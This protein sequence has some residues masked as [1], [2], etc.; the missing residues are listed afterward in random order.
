MIDNNIIQSLG[1]GSGIDTSNLTKQLTNIERT[2]PQN[3]IDTKRENTEN[4]ISDFGLISSA[5]ATLQDAAEV[6]SNPEG[7]YSKTA[8]Y[9]DSTALVPVELGTDVQAGSYTFTVEDVASS[10][11]LTSASFS[12]VDDAVGEGVLTFRFGNATADGAGAM[13]TTGGF[14][15]DTDVEDVQITIDSSN[16]SLEG[17]RDAINDADFGVQAT[18]IN[19]GVD[20]YLLQITAESG[21][22]NELEISVAEAGGSPTDNDDTGL[23]RFTFNET[24]SQL[25][26]NQ[27]GNDAVL[28]INGLLVN[29]ESNTIDDIVQGLKLDVLA[30]DPGVP[31]TITVSD[32]KAFAEQN[33]RDFVEAYNLFLDAIKPAT[34]TTEKK[35]EEGDSEKV[36]GSLANDAMTKSMLS[37][38]KSVI[39]SAVPGLSGT[40]FTSVGAI[41]IRTE[42]DGSMSIDDETFDKA[43]DENFEA[44]QKLFAPD[45][46][47]SDNSVFI[48]SYNDNT[49]AGEYEIEITTQPTRGGYEGGTL[50]G[51]TAFPNFDTTGQ[52]Y[53]FVVNVNG[54]S[55]G[56]LTIPEA[57]YASQEDLAIT[58][59]TLINSDTDVADSGSSVTVSYDSVNDRFDITSGK[60]GSS[61]NVSITTA[62]TDITTDL[63][64]AVADGTAGTTV[65]GTVNGV[66]GFGSANVLLPALGQPS[67]GMAMLVGEGA[68][69][70][71]VNFSRGFAGELENLLDEF[72]DRNGLIATR[73]TSLESSL[74]KLDDDQEALDRR[75]SSY[76]ERLMNQFIAMERI[77]NSLN[78]SGSFLD[79]LIDTLPFTATK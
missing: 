54:T 76:E 62:S 20:G 77:I 70:A 42:L 48:N 27:G 68:T 4:Q 8:S 71:T 24:A 47:T 46:S 65:V 79:S 60:Y 11:S 39:S 61:S 73:E 2:A 34:G 22:N 6:L 14:S 3:R 44:I 7:L 12:S 59:Q 74:G 33:I 40:A 78:S 67:E 51:I 13:L 66:G 19:D 75:M 64:F 17:L 35:N 69:T 5:M 15:A 36:A 53:D 49:A 50:G 63:G 57:V 1:V 72:L 25:I 26:Q 52:V 18:I 23:S 56:T 41:G 10:Q 31:V 30:A 9:T 37:K 29:R 43:I 45:T 58:L 16:N 21:A 38:I 55:S 32:D 28:T